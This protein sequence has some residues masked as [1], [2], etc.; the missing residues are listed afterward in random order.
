[1]GW[2]GAVVAGGQGSPSGLPC[3]AVHH[4]RLRPVPGAGG[5]RGAA[6]VSGARSAGIAGIEMTDT[7]PLAGVDG[8]SD[9]A[10]A[11]LAH[12]GARDRA[13][14]GP[15]A[16]ARAAEAEL[17]RRFAPRVR[18]YG[19][20][21]LGSE[22]AA[23]DL[24]QQVLLVTL[25]KLRDGGVREPDRIA[26]FVLG[27][28]RLLTREGHRA[29]RRFEPMDEPE[30]QGPVA[31]AAAPDPFARERLAACLEQLDDRGRTVV[32]LTWFGEQSAGEIAAALGV[33]EANVRVI[34]HRS[35]ARLRD[36]VDGGGAP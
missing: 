36:C 20:R 28:A 26:S 19:L 9:G 3:G 17:C 21:H 29:T 25:E 10:L 8:L 1:M 31:R 23:H 7:A 16:A 11:R 15:A 14:D 12:E 34:R 27:V 32:V 2:A 4:P 30:E 13:Q 5:G 24:V 22:S 33:S 18:L 6:G 35:V